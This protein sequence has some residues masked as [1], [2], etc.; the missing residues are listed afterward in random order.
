MRKTISV[1]TYKDY[2]NNIKHMIFK[3]LPLYEE[4]NEYLDE[5]IES[6]SLEIY[7]LQDLI[8]ELPHDQWYVKTLATLETL[9]TKI[10]CQNNQRI[11][12]KEVFKILNAIDKQIDQLQRKRGIK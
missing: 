8:A 4:K 6:I 12:K 9:K 1:Q 11:V 2:L 7:G 10:T 5:Y 3:I